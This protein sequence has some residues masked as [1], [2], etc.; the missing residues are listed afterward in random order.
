LQHGRKFNM[1][2]DRSIE[3]IEKFPVDPDGHILYIVYNKDMVRAAEELISEVHGKDYFDNFVSVTPIGGTLKPSLE[4]KRCMVYF[5]PM[6]HAH[7]GN[8]YN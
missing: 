4:G 1:I 7:N 3:T 8:G 2:T 5:D 6:F